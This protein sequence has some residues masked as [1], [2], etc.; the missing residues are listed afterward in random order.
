MTSI[1]GGY[2]RRKD[3][4]TGSHGIAQSRHDPFHLDLMNRIELKVDHDLSNFGQGSGRSMFGISQDLSIVL[5][6][7]CRKGI[8]SKP[9]SI[10]LRGQGPIHKGPTEGTYGFSQSLEGRIVNIIVRTGPNT[11]H[12]YNGSTIINDSTPCRPCFIPSCITDIGPKG[13]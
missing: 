10:F 4:F 2:G 9:F 8:L 5:I 12:P 3:P 6:G 11:T 7:Q 1:K 13:Q